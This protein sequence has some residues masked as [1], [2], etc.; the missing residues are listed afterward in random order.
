MIDW[1]FVSDGMKSIHWIRN[2]NNLPNEFGEKANSVTIG[3]IMER[4]FPLGDMNYRLLNT[5]VLMMAAYLYFVYPKE[6]LKEIDLTNVSIDD[7]DIIEQESVHDKEKLIRRIRNSV[8]HANYSIA[9]DRITFTD[10]DPQ[11]KKPD[12]I[13]FSISTVDF[14]SFIEQFRLEVF[15][16]KLK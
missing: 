4:T 8:S 7:F 5:A 1:N 16:Q 3:E 2:C 12:R 11:N 14:G 6:K 13:V 9:N 15:N 10:F